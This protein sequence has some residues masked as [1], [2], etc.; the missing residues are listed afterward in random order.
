MDKVGVFLCTGCSIGE[1]IDVEALEE[2]VDETSAK[3]FLTHP[4]LCNEEGVALICQTVV[5]E[6]LN[7]VGLL[8]C[9]PRTKVEE[10]R[11]DDLAIAVERASMREHVAWP[12]EPMHEDTQ[13][14][15]NDIVRMAVAKLEKIDL[16]DRLEESVD[17][18]VLVVGG[19]LA[20][21]TAALAA[22]GMGNPA[23]LIESQDQLG[24]YLAGV[25]HRVPE[26]PPYDQIQPNHI[27]ELIAEVE[28]KAEI[29]VHRATKIDS[30][31]GQPGQF[32]VFLT[33]PT[34]TTA[35]RVGA[36]VQATGAKPYD[37]TKL[38]TL[39]YGEVPDVVT[40]HDVETMLMNGGLRRPSDG[41]SPKR[42]VFVQCAGSRDPEHLPYCSGECCAT[43]LKLTT[44]IR[45]AD[46]G[47]ECI[48]VYRDM[49]A[50][51]Q[52]EYF[53]AG[54]QAEGGSLFTR[55]EVNRVAGDGN[56]GLTVTL[57]E[58]LLGRDV[59]LAADLVV[60]ATGMVPNSADGEAIRLFVDSKKRSETA[61][62]NVQRAEAAKIAE[63]L[64]QH[65][66]TEQLNLGYRQGPDL[67]VL[68]YNFSDS[69]YI[70][71]PYETRRTGIYTAGAV[72]APMDAAQAEEDGWGAAM[73]AVQCIAATERGE[74]VH[75]R[76]GDSSYADFALQRCTQCKRCT[77]EC[78]FGT[79]DEDEKGTPQY[80][81]LRCRRCGI[82]F[83]ACPERIISFPEY[84]VQAVASMIKAVEVPDEDEEKPR[85][86]AFM[87]E[88]DALPALEDAAKAGRKW[89]AWIRIVPVRCLGAVNTVWVADSL[90]NGFDG[91]MLIGCRK[92]DDYQCH[93][94]QGSE[95]AATRMGNVQE[96]LD[97]LQLESD[98][99]QIIELARNEFERIPQLFDGFA[100]R[101]EEMGP[102][103]Y[104]GF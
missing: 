85:I 92:G 75:P 42:V 22:V 5:A 49:R 81:P 79:I 101:I 25:A 84:K 18:T 90:S 45:Q 55:G 83:G 11:F 32:Q 51:G 50:P 96:T 35:I 1:A 63:S 20:G 68:S 13:M 38:P 26:T 73:K 94:I 53:Y 59:E 6:G 36:I 98:R 4:C 21:M 60:L 97:R 89:N 44:A 95:L 78:P 41:K 46:P 48:V 66:G 10:F 74:A 14:A 2:V 70:C 71:F 31:V 57:S 77:E 80:N 7:G 28:G 87:C 30:I 9:S 33:G 8:A 67:P 99:L 88:N 104:K 47:S 43:T 93:Y 65:Q 86:L 12:L 103:P 15:A 24:G 69:H 64:Q 52:L 37:A 27:G 39:G 17:P 91:V 23:V 29:K 61:E 3:K 82:C 58:S 56:G 102:N 76:A 54:V 62:S 100:E 72:H 40:T 19:G 16:G 34:G